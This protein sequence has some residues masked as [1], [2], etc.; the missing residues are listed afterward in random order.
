MKPVA[1][2]ARVSSERQR[3]QE[4][5]G[6]QTTALLCLTTVPL[7]IIDDFAESLS[8]ALRVLME[9]FHQRLR[10]LDCKTHFGVAHRHRAL[11]LLRLL[12]VPESLPV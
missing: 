8:R 5:I 3:E 4:T 9:L 2:Y 7:L 1:I 11:E 12:Y 10:Q 6:S